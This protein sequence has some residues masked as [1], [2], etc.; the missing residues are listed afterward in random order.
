MHYWHIYNIVLNNCKNIVLKE[1]LHLCEPITYSAIVLLSNRT[2]PLINVYKLYYYI[3][4]NTCAS[5]EHI[6]VLILGRCK[7]ILGSV[8]ISKLMIWYHSC[9]SNNIWK[10]TY[11][12]W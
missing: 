6:I 4:L 9:L 1:K 5:L 7:S 3:I 2:L 11:I 12:I 10:Y 8:K